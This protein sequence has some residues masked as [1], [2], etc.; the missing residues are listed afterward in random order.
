MVKRDLK[1]RANERQ[2]AQRRAFFN[3]NHLSNIL[4]ATKNPI[5]TILPMSPGNDYTPIMV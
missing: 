4:T 1:R 2:T 5:L 3:I